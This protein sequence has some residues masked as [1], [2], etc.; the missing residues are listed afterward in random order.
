MYQF[1][2]TITISLSSRGMY[3]LLIFDI[4]FMSLEIKYSHSL[5]A[6]TIGLHFLIQIRELGLFLSINTKA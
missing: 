1:F 5:K 2:D 3:L 6:T 4:A